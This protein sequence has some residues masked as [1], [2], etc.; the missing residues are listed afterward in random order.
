MSVS[1]PTLVALVRLVALVNHRPTS[2]A[3][4]VTASSGNSGA[5]GTA[6]SSRHPF[7]SVM[8]LLAQRA[9]PILTGA[10]VGDQVVAVGKKHATVDTDVVASVHLVVAVSRAAYDTLLLA[11]RPLRAVD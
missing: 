10:Q 4:D 5:T 7:G 3:T 8:A 2:V 9:A 6:V 1:S 11:V